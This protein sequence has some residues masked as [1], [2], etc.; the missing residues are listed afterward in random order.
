MNEHITMEK[1]KASPLPQSQTIP[2]VT[3][4]RRGRPAN[5][6]QGIN[7]PSNG[8]SSVKSDPFAALDSTSEPVRSAAMDELASRFP[9]LDEFSLLHENGSK[10]EFSRAGNAAKGRSPVDV[11]RTEDLANKAFV[12]PSATSST[13]QS[14]TFRPQFDPK[15]SNATDN[16]EK[17]WSSQESHK[18]PVSSREPPMV[19]TCTTASQLLTKQSSQDVDAHRNPQSD[20]LLANPKIRID[21]TYNRNSAS[22]SKE[23]IKPEI[24][25]PHR[26][27]LLSSQRSKS[28]INTKTTLKSP[29]SSRPSLESKR[30]NE[31]DFEEPISRSHSLKSNMRPSSMHLNSSLDYL[32]DRENTNSRVSLGLPHSDS[33]RGPTPPVRAT[34][35]TSELRENNINSDIAFLR[36]IEDDD[37]AKKRSR[38]VETRRSTKRSSLPASLSNTK[39]LLA[40]K[41]GDAFRKFEGNNAETQHHVKDINVERAYEISHVESSDTVSGHVEIAINIDE[42][43]ELVPEVRRELERMRM[44]QEEKRVSDAAAAYR[45]SKQHSRNKPKPFNSSKAA[46]IQNRVNSLL[47][48][49]D[50]SHSSSFDREARSSPPKAPTLSRPL[51][52]PSPVQKGFLDT[53]AAL[54]DSS[55]RLSN[56]KSP[57]SDNVSLKKSPEAPLTLSAT[58]ASKRPNAPPKPDALR[59]GSQ[60]NLLTHPAVKPINIRKDPPVKPPALKGKREVAED[61]EINFNKRYPSLTGLDMVEM[62]IG[63]A[64][65]IGL[66]AKN[67]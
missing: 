67:L 14:A 29:A 51:D 47:H 15:P 2:D 9:S 25:K 26:P 38:Q 41:F 11:R 64:P 22:L 55:T 32:R 39:N 48:D 42:T 3:R 27:Q 49:S 58:Q 17:T 16:A 4:M 13:Y 8:S 45:D 59:T 46:T 23:D 18:L 10:F 19:S 34:E 12:K 35:S 61:W 7:V 40:G 28:Y 33:S 56:P 44:I 57:L 50:G 24:L 52:R 54:D 63:K 36:V 5:K 60:I 20:Q 62:E 31:M 30:Q 6:A 66:P 53:S 43:E 1:Q 37:S 21:R 65:V